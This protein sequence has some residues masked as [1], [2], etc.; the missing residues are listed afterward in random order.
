MQDISLRALELLPTLDLLLC[1]DSR[2]TGQ[3]LKYHEIKVPL[4]PY[5]A[6]NEHQLT[7]Q[8]VEAIRQG[9]KLGLVTDAGMPGISDPGFLLIRA[10]RVQDLPVTVLP[11]AN[12]LLCAIVSSGLPCDRFYF[13][14][15]LPHKK[16]RQTRW[17]AI[18]QK[19]ETVVLYE[20]PHRILKCL[21]ECMTYC[22]SDRVV[23]LCRELTKIHE[24]ILRGPVREVFAELSSRSSVKGEIVLIISTEIHSA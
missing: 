21:E 14:G 18:A 20:S 23:A 24:E 5:H 7:P 13:E 2:H 12:A 19:N 15:F 1:E 8:L 11:G 17:Q 4:R 9:G 22:G 6:H 3:L 10:L 16:G